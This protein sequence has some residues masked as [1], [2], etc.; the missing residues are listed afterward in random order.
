M[1]VKDDKLNKV[2]LKLEYFFLDEIN[3][4]LAK[5][6]VYNVENKD[7]KLTISLDLLAQLSI[8][9]VK[10][11]K[12]FNVEHQDKIE[13]IFSIE[14]NKVANYLI[15]D[16]ILDFLKSRHDSHLLGFWQLMRYEVKPNLLNIYYHSEMHLKDWLSYKNDFLDYFNHELNIK[17]DT[18]EFI[19]DEE[20][21]DLQRKIIVNQDKELVENYSNYLESNK[22]EKQKKYYDYDIK[23]SDVIVPIDSLSVYEKNKLIQGQVFN[24]KKIKTKKNTFILTYYVHDLTSSICVKRFVANLSD[25]EISI[26]DEVKFLIDVEISKYESREWIEGKYKNSLIVK[27]GTELSVKENVVDRPEFSLHTKMSA[28]DGLIDLDDLHNQ[29]IINNQKHFAITDR[30][31][32]QNFPNIYNKFKKTDIKPIY[33]LELEILPVNINAVLNPTNLVISDAEYLIFDLETTG[34][35]PNY[36]DIIEFGAVIVKNCKIVERKQFFIKPTKT[37]S[38]K[39]TNITNITNSDLE[40]AISQ[41]EGLLTIS[42][43][44]ENKVLIAHNGISFDFNFLKLKFQQYGLPEIN[45]CMIDTMVISRGLN[46]DFKSHS[47][48][49]LCKKN[50]VDYDPSSAHRADYDAELLAK[51]WLIFIDL[52]NTNEIK[53]I[54]QINSAIQSNRLRQLTHGNFMVVY[55]KN[56]NGIKSIYELVSK[57]HAENFFGRPT[58]LEDDVKKHHDNLLVTNLCIESDVLN[59]A[60]SSDLKDLETKIK[61]YDFISICSDKGYYH[62]ITNEN[63]SIHDYQDAIKKIIDVSKKLNKLVIAVSNAYYLNPSDKEFHD[64]YVN[65]PTLNKKPHRF[66]KFKTGPISYLRDSNEMLEEFEFLNDKQLI[67]ELVIDNPNKLIRYFDDKISPIQH[68]LYPPKIEGVENKIYQVVYDNAHK[69]YGETLPSIVEQRIKKEL[70]SII[71]NGYAVVY[72][73]SHLLVSESINDGYV[74][75]SRGSVGSSLVATLLNITDVNPL[76]PHYLCK[77]CQYSNFDVSHEIED[78]YDLPPINCPKCNKLIY[79]EGHNILFEV[80]LGFY[81]DKIPDID[82]NFSGLYQNKAHNFIKKMFGDKYTYRA[83]TISTIAEKTSYTNTKTYFEQFNKDMNPAEIER[84]TLKCVNVKRTTGQHPGG[85]VVVPDNMSIFDFTPYNY[86]ADDKTQDW[87]TT[88][89]AFENI[90][91]NLLKFDILGHDNPTILRMLKDWTG[92]DE[93]DIPHYDKDT[94]SLFTSISCLDI[95]P[96]DVLNEKTGAISIPEFGTKFVREM[97][98]DAKPQTFADLIRISGLSHGT[99]VWVGNA[100]ELINQ[101]L[102]LK[103]IIACR[104][105]IMIYLIN[106]KIESKTAFNIMEDVRKGKQIAKNDLEVLKNNNIPD[107]YIDSCNKIE[108]MFPKAHATA[109]VMHAWKFAWYK[110]NY[111]LEYYA[112]FFSIRATS[113]NV[114]IMCQGPEA[115]KAHYNDIDSRLKKKLSVSTKEK[116]L[117]SIYEVALEMYARGFKFKMIDIKRSNA[118]TFL[119]DK[120]DNSLLLPFIA[121]DG[122]GES[123]A[124]SIIEA[125]NLKEFT[126][127]EDF[128][129]R[130]KVSKQHIDVM[131]KLKILEQLA[132]KNQISLFD[133]LV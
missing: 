75:G 76:A 131:V 30:Y 4:I 98:S 39:I 61:K 37:L 13:I 90:H 80:F 113:F 56:N 73:I 69:I 51:I 27:K 57:A 48:E 81:G 19:L 117:L 101:G 105:D 106:N 33:G 91:D 3:E 20:L 86:P 122:L 104:D 31:N 58:I 92:V 132:D 47:L 125:R 83:G 17:L 14:I 18:I 99:N 114:E 94:M 55:A 15:N 24:I 118:E 119:I 112:S 23:M 25:S 29:L 11:I 32:V 107:W 16:Y 28:Y 78:G 44:L 88:H 60:L 46:E 1:K 87:Y 100:K 74:V 5:V 9:L 50:K 63:I 65:M 95:N 124:S 72:W 2:L 41:Y 121:I 54:N 43:L 12:K 8:D 67:H 110:I 96:Q 79:G 21:I 45:N 22:K 64:L 123:V 40:N 6:N 36:D 102:N 35:Y 66:F 77:N 52:L 71:G 93:K 111:P 49:M 103:Q 53:L 85:I 126:S 129:S 34:L 84:Y 120:E 38:Q 116:D 62:E 59:A 127:Q 42:Q 10:K 128:I 115:I 89:F 68:Q 97:L 70:D 26:N 7:Q 133:S 130:T 108:Y 82:L 109:Y